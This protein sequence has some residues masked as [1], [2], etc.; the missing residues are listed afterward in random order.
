MITSLIFSAI[1]NPDWLLT[2]WPVLILA[3]LAGILAHYLTYLLLQ[4]VTPSR[5]TGDIRFVMRKLRYPTL[6]AF[7]LIMLKIALNLL[8]LEERTSGILQHAFSVT[9]IIALT[10][11][12]AGAVKIFR[13]LTLRHYDTEQKDNLLARKKVTQFQV[14]ERIATAIIVIVGIALVL[15]T[16]ES[17][18][19]LGAGLLASAGIAG[20]IIGFA[21][22]RS[23]A[24]LLAGIQI[25]LTQPIRI[26]DA[27]VVEGEWGWI[28]EINLTYVVIRIWDQRRLVVPINYFIEKPFQNWTKK[29]ADILGAVI[30]YTD[31]SVKIDA[32]R[33]EL[34]RLLA[35]SSLWDG[36]VKVVQVTDTTEKSVVVRILV[37]AGDS[38]SLWD[39]RVH[40]REKMIAFLQENYPQSLP[41]VRVKLENMPADPEKMDVE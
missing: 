6:L 14:L 2:E 39:L 9:L 1:H 40:I 34:D 19:R 28:E 33:S 36:R 8:S 38:P 10:W 35:S 15:M 5:L 17:I 29:S 18:R 31:Y 27:V 4:A 16:F 20:I 30:L 24:T 25:A 41:R 13:W 11:A 32:I 7:I 23:I 37:S 12:A 3:V 21:A 26:D 22:Q